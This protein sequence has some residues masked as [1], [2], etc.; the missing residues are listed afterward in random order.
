MNEESKGNIKRIKETVEHLK[1]KNGIHGGNIWEFKKRMESG[2]KN[3]VMTSMKDENGQ[4]EE[5][6]TKILEMYK[7]YYEKLLKQRLAETDEELRAEQQVKVL[8]RGRQLLAKKEKCKE[9][10]LNELE[11]VIKGTKR[12]KAP[13]I[14]GWRYEFLKDGGIDIKRSTLMMLNM[15]QDTGEVPGQWSRM[16]I[17]SIHKNNKD[18][19]DFKNQRGLFITSILSKLLEKIYYNRNYSKFDK[20]ISNYQCGAR[21]RRSTLDHLFVLQ[22]AIDYHRYIGTDMYVLFGDAEKCFDKLWLDDC[23][24]E[25]YMINVNLAEISLIEKMNSDIKAIVEVDGN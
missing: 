24:N 2:K 15:L 18:P 7:E 8:K 22:A 21:K 20:G 11:E 19:H 3:I 14:D 9:I 1:S 13:D 12:K 25:V 5:D 23:L 4:L 6:H 10:T 17:K 16:L